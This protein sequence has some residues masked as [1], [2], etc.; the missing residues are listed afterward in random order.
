MS[1]CKDVGA[2]YLF[3][4]FG[5][6]TPVKFID[7]FIDEFGAVGFEKD[8]NFGFWCFVESVILFSFRVFELLG[9]LWDVCDIDD[10]PESYD[11]ISLKHHKLCSCIKYESFIFLCAINVLCFVLP[12]S[13][14]KN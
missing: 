10:R 9:I 14:K 4:C 7:V 5:C 2:E 12:I 3:G 13:K 1:K 6:T 8:I 11:K